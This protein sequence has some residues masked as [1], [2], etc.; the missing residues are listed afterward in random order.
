MHAEER[1][2]RIAEALSATGFVSYRE[3]EQLLDASP[4]TIRR[5]LTRLEESG[6]IVRVHGG[7]KLPQG[8][9]AALRLGGTPFD[10][11]TS[12]TSRPFIS[13]QSL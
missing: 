11:S 1:E 10:Q 8:N 3:L 6:R 5:D 9:E 12:G 4:A 13:G 2:R 7:A